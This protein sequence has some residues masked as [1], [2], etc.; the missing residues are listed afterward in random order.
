MEYLYPNST[1]PAYLMHLEFNGEQQ[2]EFGQWAHNVE[3]ELHF[4]HVS[5][6]YTDVSRALS[7]FQ[8][9]S[10]VH[11]CFWLS[12]VCFLFLVKTNS[13]LTVLALALVLASFSTAKGD[14]GSNLFRSRSPCSVCCLF[15]S[16]EN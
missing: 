14:A 4:Y 3:K 15:P 7:C 6:F 16:V 1:F 12:M 5:Y 13:S 9:I 2:T 11:H 8:S 10:V